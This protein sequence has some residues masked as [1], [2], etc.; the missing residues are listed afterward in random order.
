M[1]ESKEYCLTNKQRKQLQHEIKNYLT[2]YFKILLIKAA[3][4]HKVEIWNDFLIFR[5]HGFLTESDKQI[6]KLPGGSDKI[7]EARLQVVK[8]Y[9]SDN[10]AYF[11]EKLGAKCIHQIYDMDVV[12]DLFIHVMI[13]DKVFIEVN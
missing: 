2:K 12:K 9:A 7:K 11:E 10:L 5:A 13:F 4:Y 1:P 3:D 6:I 8:K